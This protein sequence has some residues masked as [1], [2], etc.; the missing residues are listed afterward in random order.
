MNSHRK[1]TSNVPEVINEVWP[2][3]KTSPKALEIIKERKSAMFF[4]PF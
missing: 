2:F 4:L 1:Y 3:N